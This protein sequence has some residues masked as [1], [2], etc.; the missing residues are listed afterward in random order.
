MRTLWNFVSFLAVVHLL[1]VGMF[2]GWLWSS[3]RLDLDRL[4]E[5]KRLFSPTIAE[6]RAAAAENAAAAEAEA[7]AARDA[8]RSLTPPMASETHVQFASMLH[9]QMNQ[10]IRRLDDEKRLL[11]A[12]LA[13]TTAQ[14]EQERGAFEQE[15]KQW[16]TST[17]AERQRRIDTQF[18]KAV[19]QLESIPAKQ[20]KQILLNLVDDDNMEQAVA[21]FDAMNP[22]AAAKVLKEFKSD[23]ESVLAKE[24]LEELRRFGLNTDPAETPGNADTL[25]DAD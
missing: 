9:Q 19:K 12:Q 5:A 22:R 18:G 24:L 4:S 1:A 8:A 2:A 13:R 6:A 10:A 7:E 11:N 25:A 20:S 16:E 17:E 3:G 23:A 14:I 15:R 21:Y